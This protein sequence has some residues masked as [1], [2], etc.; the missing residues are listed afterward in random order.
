MISRDLYL[1]IKN[2]Y[3]DVA[4]WAVWKDVGVR[5]KSNMGDISMFDIDANPGILNSLKNDVIMV[6]LNFSR[7]VSSISA[8]QN[9]HD[10]RPNAQDFKI[11]FAFKDTSYY[12]AYMTDVIKNTVFL[13]SDDLNSYLR[14]NPSIIRKNISNLEIELDFINA[15]KP[16]IL[17]FGNDSYKLLFKYLRKD[18]YSDLIKIT[19]Y[20]YRIGKE[21]YREKVLNAIEIQDHK[22]E[23]KIT[24]KA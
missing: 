7:Q 11:R 1:R 12:G 22:G 9:F 8:F 14:D 2:V 20:G 10:P 6:G 19:H 16:L 5:P 15:E 13:S 24:V 23:Q 4:S 17:A 18:M 3:G 21:K